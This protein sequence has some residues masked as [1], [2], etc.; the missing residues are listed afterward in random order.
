M[1]PPVAEPIACK[2]CGQ[3]VAL[4]DLSCP[5]CQQLV[6]SDE[7]KRLAMEAERAV[8]DKDLSGAMAL[9]R[10]ALPLLP[11]DSRQH[12][13]ITARIESLRKEIEGKVAPPSWVKRAG[14]LGVAAMLLWKI[15]AVLAFVF[16]Q[17]KLLLIGLTKGTTL[18]S[19][20]L[21]FGVYW[22][23]YGWIFALGLV[24]SI[25][26]HEMGH[27][28]ALRRYG[29]A[30]TAPMFIP[31]L[32]ALVRLKQYPID[33]VED[34]RVGL[35]GPLWGLGAAAAALVMSL[36]TDSGSLAA[37]AK[38]AAWLNLFNLIP[39]WQLDGSRGFASL[40]RRDR[41]WAAGAIGLAWFLSQEGLLL[42]IAIAAAVRAL[43]KKSPEKRD[44]VAFG[45]YVFLVAALTMVAAISAR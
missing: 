9:W 42:I 45:Q 2:S 36:I 16:G 17:G 10:S 41:W 13:A 4:D 19:M 43:G 32:G 34:S 18:L 37:I 14:P 6:H 24:L 33:P 3:A 28:A 11:R 5:H 12:E 38:S 8:G 20:V 39:V 35:A 15:K 30:A 23:A 7:L 26:V 1:D 25:Y 40:T 44:P 21:F 31:G 29:I 22:R 27:V